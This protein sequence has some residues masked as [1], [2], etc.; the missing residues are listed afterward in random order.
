M[1]LKEKHVKN[2]ISIQVKTRNV[3]GKLNLKLFYGIYVTNFYPLASTYFFE[4][5]GIFEVRKFR[6]CI[7]SVR[8]TDQV[9]LPKFVQSACLVQFE[10]DFFCVYVF[11]KLFLDPDLRQ[12]I[13]LSLCGSD[14]IKSDAQHAVNLLASHRIETS[15]TWPWDYMILTAL[16][17]FF[18]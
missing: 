4:V 11:C 18:S 10:T 15:F 1:K 14:L 6:L 8:E 7:V 9:V 5:V 13:K 3:R 16:N 17:G 12:Q 2:V